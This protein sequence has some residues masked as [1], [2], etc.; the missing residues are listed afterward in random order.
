MLFIAGLLIAMVGCF[1]I[2]LDMP[3]LVIGAGFCFVGLMRLVG[4]F[5]VSKTHAA[6]KDNS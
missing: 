1:I 4:Q 2:A 6:T 5:R 3:A